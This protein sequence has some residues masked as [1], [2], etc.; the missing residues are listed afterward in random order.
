LVQKL[1]FGFL[2]LTLHSY[3]LLL[4][5]ASKIFTPNLPYKPEKGSLRGNTAKWGS[6]KVY[7]HSGYGR[8]GPE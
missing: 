3:L 4:P 6:G 1:S 8:L 2:R 7:G 5:R